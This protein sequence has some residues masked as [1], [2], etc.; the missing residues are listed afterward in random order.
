M[1]YVFETGKAEIFHDASKH[2][3]FAKANKFQGEYHPRSMLIVPIYSYQDVT[4]V[5]CADND[6]NYWFTDEDKIWLENLALYIGIIIERTN[7]IEI[8]HNIE[9]KLIKKIKEE[10]LR[11]QLIQIIKGAKDLTDAKAGV[12][13]IISKDFES[14]KYF[15]Q[16]PEQAYFPT[17]RKGEN[18]KFNG[19]TEKV[20]K[21]QFLID[22]SNPDLYYKYI[23][24]DIIEKKEQIIGVPLELVNGVKGVFFIVD[25]D[26]RIFSEVEKKVI[27][28]LAK[29]A[30]QVLN[31][32]KFI[33][34][35]HRIQIKTIK[36]INST[37]AIVNSFETSLKQILDWTSA[38]LNNASIA[39]IEILDEKRISIPLVLHG[40]PVDEKYKNNIFSKGGLIER[41]YKTKK[42][43]NCPD[44]K[45]EGDYLPLRDDINSELIIP[46]K[47]QNQIIGI[48]NIEHRKK[49]AF[50]SIHEELG[51]AIAGFVSI[52]YANQV[53]LK[54]L[55]KKNS[56]LKSAN[57]TIE[58]AENE[59]LEIERKV[60]LSA[61]SSDFV[62]NLGNRIGT[63]PNWVDLAI[64][65]INSDNSKKAIEYLTNIKRD[66]NNLMQSAHHMLEREFVQSR[67][68]CVEIMNSLM[69]EIGYFCPPR[70]EIVYSCIIKQAYIKANKQMVKD[71]IF[72]LLHNAIKS[73]KRDGKILIYVQEYFED[74]NHRNIQIQI[75]DTGIGI[76]EEKR[77]YIFTYGFSNWPQ[78]RGTG[79][80]LWRTKN[81]IESIGGKIIYLPN[82]PTGSTF[83][84]KIPLLE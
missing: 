54:E 73:I 11:P 43:V 76:S 3:W 2:P 48:I 80:G 16:Y 56:D 55:E 79:Y 49:N 84:V 12:I 46:L 4:G 38:L 39:A 81:F 8:L 44:V 18:G 52:L 69:S 7:S 82:N 68:D 57:L 33:E 1:G 20:I 62:H 19:L 50:S 59:L 5:I 42:L 9:N 61:F 27:E 15:Y 31:T 63:I 74:N 66:A 25:D 6:T 24:P 14:I 83:I 40:L 34:D 37:I 75:T 72:N 36:K 28:I 67:L 60:A 17:P 71:A 21:N 29:Q 32:T 65:E 35:N 45:F 26:S 13:Y 47:Y 22:K 23:H 77:E 53:N 41:A 64:E 58:R 30:S 10:N 51:S 78:K 70:I